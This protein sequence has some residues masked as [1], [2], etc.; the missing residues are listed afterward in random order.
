MTPP[1]FGITGWKNS[2]KTTLAA[3]LDRGALQTG[4]CGFGDQTCA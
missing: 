4:L 1:M 2:G 3:R